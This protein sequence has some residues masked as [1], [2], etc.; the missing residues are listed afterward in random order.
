MTSQSTVKKLTL[1]GVLT[2]MQIVL[3]S[4]L[5]IQFLTTKIAFAF[6]IVALTARLFSPLV[7]AGSTALAYFLGM[8]LF[9][10][11][12]FFPGFI[13]TAFLT[14]LTFGLAFQHHTTLTRVLCANFI[15]VFVWNF[16]LNSLWLH[17]MYMTPWTV[18][19]TT[20]L[21]QEIVTYLIYTAVLL[22]L[23]KVPV[24]NQLTSKFKLQ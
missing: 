14:G 21:I 11:F 18:L 8:L 23:F 17:T 9:P 3:G 10:K 5:S 7:T 1:L 16:I 19:L 4:L 20:R 13:L 12:T 24:L 22:A 6:I 15:V 2:A